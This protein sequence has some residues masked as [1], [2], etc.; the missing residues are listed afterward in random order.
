MEAGSG[1]KR[2]RRELE[3]AALGAGRPLL[4]LAR[5]TICFVLRRRAGDSRLVCMDAD[6][7]KLNWQKATGEVRHLLAGD[8]GVYLRGE[9][10][11]AFDIRTGQPRWRRAAGGCGPLTRVGGLIH[12]VDSTDPG[13][14]VALDELTGT[15]A[16]E[17]AGIRSCDAFRRIG[18][19]GYIK[20][21]DGIVHAIALRTY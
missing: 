2:W 4:A 13:R 10:I 19:T 8:H 11:Q 1:Q 18:G 7:G 12:F 9:D 16:W 6:T 15:T 5:G 20:T 14:L 17:I 21:H 3:A